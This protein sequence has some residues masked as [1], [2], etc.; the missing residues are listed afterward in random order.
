M[1]YKNPDD[2][3]RHSRANKYKNKY[4]ITIEDYD[5]MLEDQGGR[6]AICRTNDPGGSGSRFAVDHDH[7]TGKVRGLLCQNCNTG[8]G[9]LQDNVLILEQAIRYLNEKESD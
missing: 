9:L 2:R 7:K 8:I 1:P 3:R 6:C 4:G 5:R